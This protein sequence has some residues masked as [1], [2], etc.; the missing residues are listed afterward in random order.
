MHGLPWYAKVHRGDQ[1]MVLDRWQTMTSSNSAEYST[2]FRVIRP[3]GEI[4]WG[5]CTAIPLKS[6]GK[7]TGYVGTVEDITKRLSMLEEREEFIA[8]LTHDLKNPLIGANRVLEL[9]AD[10]QIGPITTGQ[11][12]LLMQL[13]DSNM[14][15]LCL[16]QNLLEVYRLEKD[17]N[18]LLL[19]DHDLVKLASMCVSEIMPIAKSKNIDVDI[20]LPS[21]LPA[22]RV[23]GHAIQRVLQN[24]IDNALKFTP[25]GG[26]ITVELSHL[27]DIIEFRV[28]DTGVGIS[29]KEQ[30]KLFQRFAQGTSGKKYSPGTGL[31]LYLCKQIVDAHKG[32]ITCTSE[33]GI[34]TTFQ[35]QLPCGV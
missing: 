31:G 14:R 2:E 35:I 21:H 28:S 27:E 7:V 10:Q 3:D 12:E 23:D 22:S 9:L 16:I 26:R 33:E 17:V 4:I 19:A 34:G 11:A 24:L 15:L 8:T 13:R 32:S 30:K 20:K 18:A 6:S 5:Q 1:K 29:K 25:R